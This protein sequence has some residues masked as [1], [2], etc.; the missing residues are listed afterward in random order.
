MGLTEQQRRI[1]PVFIALAVATGIAVTV[2]TM[3]HHRE[4]TGHWSTKSIRVEYERI[5]PPTGS[6]ALGSVDTLE[7]YGATTISGRYETPDIDALPYYQSELVA[8]GWSYLRDLQGGGHWG[9]SF[10]KDKLLAS[11]E[12]LNPRQYAFSISWN[13]ISENACP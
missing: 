9:K 2:Y 13:E 3:T 8:S 11:V 4:R 5:R 12:M 1:R 10:C 7:K 6:H